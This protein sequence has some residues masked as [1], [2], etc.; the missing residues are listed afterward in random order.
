[1]CLCKIDDIERM[2]GWYATTRGIR[3]GESLVW[4][5]LVEELCLCFNSLQ[6]VLNVSFEEHILCI[7]RARLNG[8]ACL[9]C[10][11]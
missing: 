4:Y 10:K 8:K 3:V 7:L 6:R 11:G 9:V 5:L 2:A 1:M